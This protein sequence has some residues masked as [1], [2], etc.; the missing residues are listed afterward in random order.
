MLQ[1]E[2]DSVFI[3]VIA[4][5]RNPGGADYYIILRA[6]AC[7]CVRMR[8]RVR[9]IPVFTL[10]DHHVPGFSACLLVLGS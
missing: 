10:E 9:I 1:S 6:S 4:K 2:L 3:P 5:L 8:V 7:E